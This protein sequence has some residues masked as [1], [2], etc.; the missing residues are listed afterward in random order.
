MAVKLIASIKRYLGLSG[1]SKPTADTPVGS[2]FY[3][4]DTGSTYIFDGSSWILRG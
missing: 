4:T 2:T 1:D 3:E